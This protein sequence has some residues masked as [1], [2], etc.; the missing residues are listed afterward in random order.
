MRAFLKLHGRAG[1]DRTVS[2]RTRWAQAVAHT[3]ARACR[4]PPPL[5]L[6]G[7]SPR[8]RRPT[9][10]ALSRLR[11][12]AATP[13][14]RARRFRRSRSPEPPRLLASRR[15]R[16]SDAS[17]S[18]EGFL[19]ELVERLDAE[20]GPAAQPE[21]IPPS[22]LGA[23][24]TSRALRGWRASRGGSHLGL[25]TQEDLLDRHLELLARSGARHLSIATIASG[26]CAGAVLAHPAPDSATSSS[27]SSAAAHDE[28]HESAFVHVDH[29]P[30]QTSDILHRGVD[31]VVPMRS[32]AAVDRGVRAPVDHG[33]AALG[34]LDPVAVAP[35]ARVVVEVAG[36][37]ALAVGVVPEVERHRGHRLVRSRVST[38]STSGRPS[39]S[40]A[41]TAAPSARLQLARVDGHGQP[42]TNAV[43]D[44]CRRW[45]RTARR[46][47]RARRPTRSPRGSGEPVE[48]GSSPRG[49]RGASRPPSC[50]RR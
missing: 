21:A 35:D 1:R 41:S 44:R 14:P 3:R 49:P 26:M 12:A 27:S 33:G 6:C 22:P 48:L 43:Q 34:D 30:V 13:S 2:Q 38:S 36:R 39:S 25:A 11:L 24:R 23:R 20:V 50:T 37:V 18:A 47:R 19:R 42:F 29:E 9:T 4:C 15:R 8:T 16:T 10:G 5:G 31:L 7:R 17:R 40:H 45:W 46:R 32:P 28:Q